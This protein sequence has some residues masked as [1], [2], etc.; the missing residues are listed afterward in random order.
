MFSI[1]PVVDLQGGLV[2]RAKAGER[3]SYTPI[4]T[5]LSASAAPIEVVAGLLRAWPARQLYIADLDAIQGRGAHDRDVA[6]IAHRFPGLELWVDAGFDSEEQVRRYDLPS[7]GRIVL[8]SESQR[9]ESLVLRLGDRAIL[10]LDT[11][12][13]LRL[14]PARLHEDSS[15]WPSTVIVMTLARVG[16]DA[17]PDLDRLRSVTMQASGRTIIAAGG[18]RDLADCGALESIGVS[19]ALVASALHDGRI[20]FDTRKGEADASP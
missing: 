20:R 6:A 1:I 10:S 18:L 14:G 19:G 12:G 15:L 8:G 11:R 13:D 5:P 9:D 7:D 17:G 16:M 2:V 3:E 4:V